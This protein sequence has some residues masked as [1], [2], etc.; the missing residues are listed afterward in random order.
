[1][2]AT[3]VSLYSTLIFSNPYLADL[4]RELS[5]VAESD[6]KIA[7]RSV[8]EPGQDPH[9]FNLKTSDRLRIE[10]AKVFFH[11][12]KTLEYWVPQAENEF[13]LTLPSSYKDPHIWHSVS[14]TLQLAD[15]MA[16]QMILM[17][18]ALKT[19]VL[20]CQS[21]FKAKAKEFE[22]TSK[23]QFGQISQ[24]KKTIAVEH[25]SISYLAE[26]LNLKVVS[27]RGADLS[28]E[29]SPGEVSK[30][31]D[32]LKNVTAVFPPDSARAKSLT[33]VLRGAKVKLGQPL[34]YEGPVAAGKSGSTILKMWKHNTEVLY[35]GLIN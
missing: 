27:L 21:L 16:Q 29:L 7:D 11:L 24:T 35:A 15:Q 23:T 2:S 26:M 6:S 20:K 32:Q 28:A 25:N 9:E 4:G 10:K 1:M 3:L 13:V 34:I 30:F 33:R 22:K 19:E 14:A 12:S 5:C 8:I 17:N 18:S 31:T